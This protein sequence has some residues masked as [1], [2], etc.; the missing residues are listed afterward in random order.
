MNKNHIIGL[1][2][3][4]VVASLFLFW[5]MPKTF[6]ATSTHTIGGDLVVSGAMTVTGTSTLG[7]I[8]GNVPNTSV[9]TMTSGTTTPCATQN[10]SGN[11]L[12]LVA[13]GVLETATPGGGTVGLSVGTSTT[14]FVTSTSP[15]VSNSTF[16]NS[17]S[18]NIISTTS[19]LQTTYAPWQNNEWLVWKTTTST[20]AGT[21]RVL[22]Y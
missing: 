11:T 2:I 17:S 4:V 3:G 20:N 10:T 1:L 18:L 7:L 6:G 19:S 21:C 15:L 16:S 9:V 12:T 13:I 22:Y 5:A 8:T 14:A